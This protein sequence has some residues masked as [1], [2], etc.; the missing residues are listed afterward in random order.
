M[1]N[2]KKPSWLALMVSVC[3]AAFGVQNRENLDRDFAQS[4]ALPFIIAGILFTIVFVLA[5]FFLVKLVLV[6]H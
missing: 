6:N 1:D 4:S 3:A 5:V 2:D